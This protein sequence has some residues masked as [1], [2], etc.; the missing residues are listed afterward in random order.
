[1]SAPF[2][3]H[4]DPLRGAMSELVSAQSS[5]NMHADP[6]PGATGYV[7]ETDA[8]VKHAME[9]LHA[10]FVLLHEA[11]KAREVDRTKFFRVQ[12]KLAEHRPNEACA[13]Y[14]GF[15]TALLG[16]GQ[17]GLDESDDADGVRDSMD[18]L[19]HLMSGADQAHARALVARLVEQFDEAGHDPGDESR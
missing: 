3:D 2:L 17:I 11:W 7:S 15:A 14:V 9:H 16:F 19:W 10:V 13:T 12:Q 4:D 5:L 8:N 6:I 1:M 18:T